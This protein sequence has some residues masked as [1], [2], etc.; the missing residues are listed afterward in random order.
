MRVDAK[1]RN[2]GKEITRSRG[3]NIIG[4]GGPELCFFPISAPNK[5]QGLM[6][7]GKSL[8]GWMKNYTTTRI[9]RLLADNSQTASPGFATL[10]SNEKRLFETH[11]PRQ[12]EPLGRL[13]EGG[14]RYE[15]GDFLLIVQGCRKSRCSAKG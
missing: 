6:S 13:L 5:E 7:E 11:R 10:F 1:E 15:R 9:I 3:T 8:K 4:P 14:T 2:T 12:Q